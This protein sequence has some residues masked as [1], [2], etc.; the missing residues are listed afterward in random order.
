MGDLNKIVIPKTQVEWEDIAYALC[1]EIGT[2]RGIR[3]KHNNNPRKCCKELFEDWLSTDHGVGPKTWLTLLDK[4]KE[5]EI[6]TAATDEIM[7][8]LKEIALVKG[9]LHFS[10]Q[11]YVSQISDQIC[12]NLACTHNYKE[13]ISSPINSSINTITN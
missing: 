2:V 4:L 9:N 12:Q 10:V 7:D 11:K 13:W 1:Y 6:L 3:A 5:I 8:D